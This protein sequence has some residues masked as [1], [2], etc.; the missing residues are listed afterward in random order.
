ML[1]FLSVNGYMVHMIDLSGFG[2]SGGPRGHSSMAELHHDI[3]LALKMAEPNYPL[4]IFGHSMGGALVSSL[5]IQNPNLNI[6]GVISSGAL[7]G[8]PNEKHL[9]WIIK[10]IV[11]MGGKALDV[12]KKI[13]N[14]N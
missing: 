5:M 1:D 10:Q 8:V 4:F 7:F 2:Q 12:Y 9:P 14:V 13:F 11:I 3:E 6:A